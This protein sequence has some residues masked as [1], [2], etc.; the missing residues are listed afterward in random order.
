MG[1]LFGTS[2]LAHSG[3]KP[4]HVALASSPCW[5]KVSPGHHSLPSQAWMFLHIVEGTGCCNQLSRNPTWL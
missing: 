3:Y 4:P 1:V 5:G 2:W